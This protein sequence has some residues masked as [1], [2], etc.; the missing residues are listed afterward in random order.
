MGCVIGESPLVVINQDQIDVFAELTG[1]NQWIHTD[2]TLAKNGPY[3]ETIVHGYLLLSLIP[4]F[5]V[6][7][8]SIER[9]KM[10]INYGINRLRFL[11][12]LR[13]DTQIYSQIKLLKIIG[14]NNHI[15]LYKEVTVL[16]PNEIKPIL[17]VENI[18]MI[19]I[20]DDK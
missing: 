15:K 20:D 7:S 14:E 10:R 8:Y 2:P 13:V 19:V 9:V 16:R 17:V 12:P 4:M 6:Q 11:T 18:T 5:E 3:G 1:D